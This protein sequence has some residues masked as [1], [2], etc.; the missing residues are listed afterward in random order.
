MLIRTTS[1]R[2]PRTQA[3][4]QRHERQTQ[5][6]VPVCLAVEC[7]SS[8]R[9]GRGRVSECLSASGRRSVWRLCVGVSF[10]FVLTKS[11]GCMSR[12]F[13]I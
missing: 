12:P 4:M 1:G 11:C 9:A 5:A 7:L 6:P 2:K 3:L 8:D 13:F 10:F